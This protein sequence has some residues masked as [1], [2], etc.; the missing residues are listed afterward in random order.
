MDYVFSG[1]E[2]DSIFTPVQFEIVKVDTDKI[3][4]RV[5]KINKD[6]NRYPALYYQ[7]HE[8]LDATDILTNATLSG[9]DKDA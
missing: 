6:N 8:A 2:T 1:I 7:V 3:E 9:A 5:K 4:V